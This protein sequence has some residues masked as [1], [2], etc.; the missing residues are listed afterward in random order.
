MT[1]PTARQIAEELAR[2]LANFFGAG[3]WHEA[4]VADRI[5]QAILAAEQR[6]R[7]KALEEAEEVWVQH[8]GQRL[9]APADPRSNR[10][11]PVKTLDWIKNGMN[12]GP[13]QDGLA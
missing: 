4:P 11:V 3:E 6:A 13:N 9:A 8:G 1:E 10:P 2:E 12:L 5:E 7:E